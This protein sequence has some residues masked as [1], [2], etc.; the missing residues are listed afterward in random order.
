MN[1]PH[2]SESYIVKWTDTSG[3]YHIPCEK[4]N[5]TRAQAQEKVAE[6]EAR[7]KRYY[8]GVMA[9]YCPFRDVRIDTEAAES[10]RSERAYTR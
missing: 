1:E 4:R 3:G 8:T 9:S 5:L 10:A 2:R 6:F 7:R